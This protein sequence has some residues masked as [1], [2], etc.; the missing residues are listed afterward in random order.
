MKVL[1]TIKTTRTATIDIGNLPI[2]LVRDLLTK[3]DGTFDG[4][5]SVADAT[6]DDK[7]VT[8]SVEVVEAGSKR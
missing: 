2:G 5:W 4:N 3:N 1:I 7:W 8:D 6:R